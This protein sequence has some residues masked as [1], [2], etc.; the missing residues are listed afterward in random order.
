[1]MDGLGRWDVLPASVATIDV[2]EWRRERPY[3][4]TDGRGAGRVRIAHA[5]NHRGFKGT[6][7]MSPPSTSCAPRAW[8]SSSC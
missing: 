6:E 2:A 3:S 5:L 7:F 4:R 8:M 1:M